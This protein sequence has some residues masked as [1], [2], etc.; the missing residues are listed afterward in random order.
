L[1]KIRNFDEVT[2]TSLIKNEVKMTEDSHK[3]LMNQNREA[4][5]RLKTKCESWLGTLDFSDC[6]GAK[7]LLIT[8]FFFA[9]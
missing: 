2:V 9:K 1:K 4:D 6:F 5:L 7:F 3:N 8:L